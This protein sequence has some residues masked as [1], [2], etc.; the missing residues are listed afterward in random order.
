MRAHRSSAHP[1]IRNKLLHRITF[2]LFFV[3]PPVVFVA[4]ALL[5][6]LNTFERFPTL[7]L[8]SRKVHEAHLSVSW[9]PDLYSHARSTSFREA[10]T[11]CTSF[12]VVWWIYS[13]LGALIVS[14]AEYQVFKENVL[15][16]SS[17]KDLL[18]GCLVFIPLA[19][20]IIYPAFA[21]PGD[22]SFS[23]GI[24]TGSRIG[25]ALMNGMAVLI[26]SVF[27][28]FWPSSPEFDTKRSFLAASLSRC[29]R[30]QRLGGE[31]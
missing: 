1:P 3:I 18:L 23:E 2:I 14:I 11:V 16:N 5:L 8:L 22:Y 19:V 27:A 9:M 21:I 17:G 29:Q 25:Y 26:S 31:R 30:N 7:E 24:T 4:L 15:K 28:G 12:A 10:A 6:P 13:A 20:A